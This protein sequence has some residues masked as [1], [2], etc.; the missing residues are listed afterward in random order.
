MNT[1]AYVD[2]LLGDLAALAGI[3]EGPVAEAADRLAGPLRA[4]ASMRLLD[5]LGEG[6]VEV[7]AQLPSGHV[8]V[9]LA[10]QEPSF[11]FVDEEPAGEQLD[12]PTEEGMNARITL[13][14]PGAL[15]ESIERAA[16]RDRVSANTWIVREL[17]RSTSAPPPRRSGRRLTGYATS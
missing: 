13:R 4:Q 6:A 2:G 9:R 11:V 15:K 10:G 14:L 16:S 12:G 8:E 17:T 5:L 1:T 7:S 3:G